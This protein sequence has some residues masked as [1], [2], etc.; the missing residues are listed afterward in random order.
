M[1][2]IASDELFILDT[3]PSTLPQTPEEE[4]AFPSPT[5]SNRS[6]L[7]NQSS[8]SVL[9]D[10]TPELRLV[11]EGISHASSHNLY[12]PISST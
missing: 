2:D 7:E 4:T 3:E 1:T 6:V 5:T 8:G 10:D 12:Q 11:L 9:D